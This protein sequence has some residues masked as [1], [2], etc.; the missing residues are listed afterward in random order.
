MTP[1]LQVADVNNPIIV[2]ERYKTALHYGDDVILM[3]P[4]G[5]QRRWQITGM[6][7]G[8]LRAYLLSTDP[9]VQRA[10]QAEQQRL[11]VSDES[12]IE[13]GRFV[14]GPAGR[15]LD[16]NMKRIYSAPQYNTQAEH[17]LAEVE[18]MLNEI[19][20][21]EYGWGTEKIGAI[22]EEMR[23]LAND[24]GK[25]LAKIKELHTQATLLNKPIEG[26]RRGFIEDTA[27]LDEL[28][29]KLLRLDEMLLNEKQQ[30]REIPDKDFV[31]EVTGHIEEMFDKVA[32]GLEAIK[33]KDLATLRRIW[34][35]IM[36]AE[37]KLEDMLS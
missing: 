6:R 10:A 4:G 31:L 15:P 19:G 3:G 8:P 33:T 32:E 20:G 14:L 34:P 28:R 13:V 17:M 1:I 12:H 2:T 21:F 29:N 16:P 37:K 25:N 18:L 30:L 35:E 5:S 26:R 22:R 23:A 27:D 11:G 36:R 24:G 9:H 7:H